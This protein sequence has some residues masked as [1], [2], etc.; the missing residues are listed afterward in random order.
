M[1]VNNREVHCF[2]KFRLKLLPTAPNY[3]DYSSRKPHIG[4]NVSGFHVQDLEGVVSRQFMRKGL[5][6]L[7]LSATLT[8]T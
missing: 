5:G 2:V 4:S 3:H 1:G 6:F 7:T 8:A